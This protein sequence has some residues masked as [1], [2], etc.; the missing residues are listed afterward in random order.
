[1]IGECLA[2]TAPPGSALHHH[3]RDR[4]PDSLRDGRKLRGT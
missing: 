1:M 4:L 2:D 3:R